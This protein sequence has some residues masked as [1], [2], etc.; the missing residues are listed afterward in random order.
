MLKMIQ[1]KIA[2]GWLDNKEHLKDMM[3]EMSKSNELTD[4]TLIHCL[5]MTINNSKLTKL[6]S[7]LAALF[8]KIFLMNFHSTTQLFI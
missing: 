6:F 5:V 4:V 7:F 3:C 2:M 8:S 1:A